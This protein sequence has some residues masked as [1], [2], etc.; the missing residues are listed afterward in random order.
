MR[1]P[2]EQETPFQI[3]IIP[4]VDVIF[5]ILTFFV[6]STLFLTRSEGLPVDLPQATT[7]EAQRNSQIVV[8]ILPNGAIYLNRQ[9]IR[10][11]QLEPT[12]RSLIPP[13]SQSVVILNA[14][15]SVPLGRVVS[16]MDRLR[17]VPGVRL[18]IAAQS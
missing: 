13:N 17:L 7:A 11:N 14:D 8:T 9:P 18:A 12:V 10:L 4:M 15:E 1:L 6:I 2:D 5:A 16:V 3:N